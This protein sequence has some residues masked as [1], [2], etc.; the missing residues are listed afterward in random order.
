MGYLTICDLI[1]L[2]LKEATKKMY[3]NR[4]WLVVSVAALIAL[5]LSACGGGTS[6]VT[7]GG[8]PV[9]LTQITATPGAAVAG[10]TVAAPTSTRTPAPTASRV[11]PAATAVVIAA[12]ATVA[13]SPTPV[14]PT[15]T[16]TPALAVTVAA[17][18][19][20]TTVPVG[21]LASTPVATV[22]SATAVTTNPDLIPGAVANAPKMSVP[23][24]LWHAENGQDC[25]YDIP[26][27]TFLPGQPGVNFTNCTSFNLAPDGDLRVEWEYSTFP[28]F[29]GTLGAQVTHSTME[30]LLWN[31]TFPQGQPFH[32]GVGWWGPLK[33]FQVDVNY[34][35]PDG[36][37]T[38]C[39]GINFEVV[40]GVKI[41]AHFK[42]FGTTSAVISQGPWG[43][44]S[45]R[46]DNPPECRPDRTRLP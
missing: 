33:K 25:Q 8:T 1:Q 22:V 36:S 20:A 14:P 10:V 42:N 28:Y 44:A 41:Q 19:T 43:V 11:A 18:A 15:W 24:L 37:A 2:S 4:S 38:G 6:G 27:G 17:G 3:K 21:T 30:A 29:N 12:P 7:S 46:G 26:F 31:W 35:Y 13:A 5:V 40:G 16:N 9:A 45:D 34:V 39:T 32:D 23:P